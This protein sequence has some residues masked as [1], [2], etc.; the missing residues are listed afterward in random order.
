M[1]GQRALARATPATSAAHSWPLSR[2]CAACSNGPRRRQRSS[3]C[4]AGESVLTR[5]LQLCACACMRSARGGGG[6]RDT[7]HLQTEKETSGKEGRKMKRSRNKIDYLALLPQKQWR[8]LQ[9]ASPP[10]A[11]R[12]ELVRPRS[13]AATRALDCACAAPTSRM[14][15]ATRSESGLPPRISAGL[16]ARRSKSDGSSVGSHNRVL[17]SLVESRRT[18]LEWRCSALLP[19][20]RMTSLRRVMRGL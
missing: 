20:R 5:S 17:R 10:S 6:V 3:R 18:L 11:T 8:D 7:N 15:L 12:K 4:N 9:H 13:L 16:N 14:D 1:E 19:G 2:S